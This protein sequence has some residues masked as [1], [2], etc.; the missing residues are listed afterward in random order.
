MA[1]LWVVPADGSPPKQLTQS[2]EG[3]EQSPMWSPDGKF[4]AYCVNAA[5]G[6]GASLYAIGAEGGAPKRLWTWTTPTGRGQ[7]RH[8]WFPDSK[9]MGVASDDGVVAVA[10]ADG[11]VPPLP[12]AGGCRSHLALVAAM[13]SGR[14]DPRSVRGRRW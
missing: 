4:I 14:P 8:A 6:V 10:V 3:V 5:G 1:D 11:T 7:Q 2:P 12:E 9:E 13:V